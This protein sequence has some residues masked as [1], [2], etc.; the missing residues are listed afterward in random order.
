MRKAC[1]PRDDVAMAAHIVE[2]RLIAERA[3]ER[4]A[5]L[6]GRQ[7]LGMNE[8]QIQKAALR[9]GELAVDPV[10]DG[11]PCEPQCPRI[12][13]EG[14]GRAPMNVSWNLGPAG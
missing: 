6:L 13:G 12:G 8:G 11:C 4:H 5:F 2:R 9:V 3:I 1:E 7:I 14:R 10:R